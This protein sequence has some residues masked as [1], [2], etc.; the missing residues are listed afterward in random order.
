[1]KFVFP[2]SQAVLLM[3]VFGV[4]APFP[5]NP[6]CLF[7]QDRLLVTK[8]DPEKKPVFCPPSL[9][10]SPLPPALPSDSLY[11]FSK[12]TFPSNATPFVPLKAS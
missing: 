10:P 3:I 9:N 12:A 8:F 11:P 1:M 4:L 2:L 5:S 6:C 7:R